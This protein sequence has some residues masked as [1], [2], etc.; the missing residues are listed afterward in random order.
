MAFDTLENL[1][2]LSLRG[3]WY[4]PTN[5]H[6]KPSSL[7]EPDD[8]DWVN[9][10]LHLV[11]KK[12]KR[13][14]LKNWL[15]SPDLFLSW[16]PESEEGDRWALLESLSVQCVGY[17]PSARWYFTGYGVAPHLDAR[18]PNQGSGDLLVRVGLS[19]HL[20]LRVDAEPRTLNPLMEAMS[21]ALLRMDKLEHATFQLRD[22]GLPR[23]LLFEYTRG[24]GEGSEEAGSKVTLEFKGEWAIP[25]AIM[26]C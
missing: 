17:S 23:P 21:R 26:N 25:D 6:F 7:Y 10:S 12:L 22:H 16:H 8:Y 18:K 4:T 1:T 13:L 20:Q 3:Q 24:G 19:P 9:R 11:S 5:H 15:V 14:E 2:V